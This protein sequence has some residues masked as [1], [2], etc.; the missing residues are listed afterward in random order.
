MSIDLQQPGH[1][2]PPGYLIWHHSYTT[3]EKELL[4]IVETN[5]NF[6]SM[7]LGADIHIYT[8]HCNLIYNTLSTQCVL[9]WRLFIED[10][11]PTFHCIKGLD[12]VVADALSCHPI[13][14][15][16]E[17]GIIQNDVDPDYNAKGFSFELDNEPLLECLLHHPHLSDD[18][19]FPLDYP[20]LRSQQ[21]QDII[22]LQQQQNNPEKYPTINLDGTELICYVTTR[23]E[24]WCIAIPET[25]LDSI[26]SWY[27][28]ILSHIGMTRLYNPI[29]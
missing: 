17:V 26:I 23:G 4:S 13:E 22:L 28:Q 15:L 16:S 12:N 8:D 9:H 11:H 10:F 21:L 2:R 1:R 7:L 24:P 25:L 19:V 3:I 6:R 5:Q 14:A 18:I 20:L 29:F 27:H